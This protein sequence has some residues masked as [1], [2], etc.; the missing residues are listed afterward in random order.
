M[1]WKTI[2]R[3][4]YLSDNGVAHSNVVILFTCTLITVDMD[5]AIPFL[6][7]YRKAYDKA[8][9]VHKKHQAEVTVPVYNII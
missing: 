6:F 3:T 4:L 8:K 9:N 1:F 7:L 2:K 5:D